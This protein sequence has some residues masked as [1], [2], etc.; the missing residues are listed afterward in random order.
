MEIAA[1]MDQGAIRTLKN[2][3]GKERYRRKNW[4]KKGKRTGEK[5]APAS[6]AVTIGWLYGGKTTDRMP[7]GISSR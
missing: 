6:P 1:D 3:K 2:S 4:T 7:I 5:G